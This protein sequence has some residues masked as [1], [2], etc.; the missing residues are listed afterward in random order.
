M[1]GWK[2]LGALPAPSK[3]YQQG[4]KLIKG[5]PRRGSGRV[6]LFRQSRVGQAVAPGAVLV[7]KA[8]VA[9]CQMQKILP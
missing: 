5:N 4:C 3:E 1:C 6:P 2:G 7:A 9:A 8:A